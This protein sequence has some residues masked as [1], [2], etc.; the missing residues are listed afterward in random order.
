MRGALSPQAKKIHQSYYLP[1][2]SA[3]AVA[4]FEEP[5]G[6]RRPHAAKARISFP[7]PE[8]E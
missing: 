6:S 3:M 1:M 8:L 7:E 5:D 4:V 2:T